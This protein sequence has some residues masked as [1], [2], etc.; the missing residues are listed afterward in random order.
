[1]SAVVEQRW[2]VERLSVSLVM[3]LFFVRHFQNVYSWFVFVGNCIL[4]ACIWR[5]S[6]QASYRGTHLKLNMLE[7]TRVEPWVEDVVRPRTEHGARCSSGP[8]HLIKPCRRD[9]LA[10][11]IN[12]LNFSRVFHISEAN[13]S[14]IVSLRVGS[15]Q[16]CADWS[17]SLRETTVRFD[18][19]L[20]YL[21]G[22][23]QFWTTAVI[24]P[25]IGSSSDLRNAVILGVN[26][27]LRNVGEKRVPP[28]GGHPK[29]YISNSPKLFC[30]CFLG[31]YVCM[32]RFIAVGT[33]LNERVLV[34]YDIV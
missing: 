26:K 3:A 15:G 10:L 8:L 9:L 31:A 33:N 17:V 32:W 11:L 28:T 12:T 27:Y 30:F 14:S 1:M 18:S 24:F 20:R 21:Y 34:Y 2:R 16:F 7:M 25:S 22:S 13:H 29:K 23:T 6:V 19:V 4:V 5:Q